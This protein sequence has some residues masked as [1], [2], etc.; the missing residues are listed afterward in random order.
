M[1]IRLSEDFKRGS[2][3]TSRRN[4][5]AT[6]NTPRKNSVHVSWSKVGKYLYQAFEV[7]REKIDAKEKK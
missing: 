4:I 2:S 3:F 5:K 6:Y 1:S 7:E